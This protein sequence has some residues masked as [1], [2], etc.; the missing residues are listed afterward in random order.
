MKSEYVHPFVNAAIRVLGEI[1]GD[2]VT[3]DP[4][5]LVSSLVTTQGIAS[6]VGIWGEAEGRMILDMSRDTAQGLAS[7]MKNQDIIEDDELISAT[8]NELANIIA[9]RAVSE[10]VN[11]GH[12][13][14]ITSPT[15]FSGKEMSVFNA[16][17]ETAAVPLN[18]NFGQ[19]IIN[20]AIRD[21]DR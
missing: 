13:F 19:V 4:V 17:L 5:S 8:V 11:R 9:G 7:A 14:S 20:L 15:L 18:T 3:R 12:R 10:L 16:A 1:T 2:E 6:L 21:L